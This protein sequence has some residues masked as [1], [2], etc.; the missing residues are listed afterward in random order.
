MWRARYPLL[1]SGQLAVG[2]AQATG[3][4]EREPF[5]QVRLQPRC[6]GAHALEGATG[7]HATLDLAQRLHVG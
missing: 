2:L 1:Q 5:Q 4:A 6:L 3:D 7:Q